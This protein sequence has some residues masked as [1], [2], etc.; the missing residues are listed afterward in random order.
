MIHQNTY[1]K[2]PTLFDNLDFIDKIES[3]IS[4]SES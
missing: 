3:L 4:D 1:N 2:V